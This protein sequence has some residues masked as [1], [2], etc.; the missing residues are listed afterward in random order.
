M[1]QTNRTPHFLTSESVTEGHPDKICD[2]ISDG[3][4]DAYL[5]QDPLSRVAVETMVSA[6]AVMIAGEITSQGMV[7]LPA[8]ARK[9]I[10]KIGYTEQN[11]GFDDKTCLV[12][13]N[14]HHQSG[15]IN[16]GVT[17]A[18]GTVEI[19]GGDQGIMYGYASDETP[20]LMPLPCYLASRLAQRLAWFRK[21]GGGSFLR[22][23]GKTQITMRYDQEGRATG[24][25]SIVVSAQHGATIRQEQIHETILRDVIM[26]VAGKW[27]RDDTVVHINPTGRFVIGGPAGDVGV[28]GRKIM[29][30]TYGT[31]ARHGGG[32][33]SGKDATKVDRSAAYM[34]RYAAK[35]IVAAGLA[36]RCEISVAYVIGSI[37]PEAVTVDAFGTETVPLSVIE[38]VVQDEFPFSVAGI[39]DCLD[40]RRPQFQRSAVYG[41]FGRESEGFRWEVTDKKDI[42]Q[43]KAFR[44]CHSH[45]M[46]IIEQ[47]ERGNING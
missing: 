23:D 40:L 35:N 13:C 5:E 12:L 14:V 3:I 25:Q 6:N 45:I 33:F 16:L 17:K 4:L 24:L 44:I 42:V 9:I 10:R 2:Q 46:D 47:R 32:A 15:D 8:V 31:L 26:P 11:S 43:Q 27:L 19:G 34:A 1:I 41:H 37:R 30:D 22:P 28:T 29:V 38:T 7:D 36:R 20:V 21:D 39:I 18:K